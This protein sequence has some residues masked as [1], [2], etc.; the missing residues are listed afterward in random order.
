[1]IDYSKWDHLD[2]S[3]S[4]EEEES[5]FVPPQVTKLPASSKV[6][7]S[8][9]EIKVVQTEPEKPISQQPKPKPT[10]ESLTESQIKQLTHNGNKGNGYY[11]SQTRDEVIISIVVPALTRAKDVTLEVTDYGTA[12]HVK[13]SD[14][15]LVNRL[16][17]GTVESGEDDLA[18]CWELKTI[19]NER[20]L[21]VTLRKRVLPGVPGA[22][23]WG[24][25]YSDEEGEGL[26][27]EDIDE[28]DR[29]GKAAEERR[30]QWEETWKEAQDQFRK[31]VEQEKGKKVII[32]G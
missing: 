9:G 29:G 30:K 20:L 17:A 26:K 31:K 10:Q 22:L 8:N 1:M 19:G 7:I 15:D 11:W 27:W 6:T 3:D 18:G 21:Q 12:F 5:S 24:K 32:D 2:Y 13:I 28:K 23:W 4:D 16:F 25:L 14:Y